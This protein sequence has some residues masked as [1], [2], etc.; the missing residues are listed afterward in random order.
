MSPPVPSLGPLLFL[1]LDLLP[2]SLCISKVDLRADLTVYIFRSI[3]G[4]CA[5]HTY[6]I[7]TTSER[8][9]TFSSRGYSLSRRCFLGG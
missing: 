9:G 5:R 7:D 6:Q 4:I 3:S 2:L 1:R 8:D